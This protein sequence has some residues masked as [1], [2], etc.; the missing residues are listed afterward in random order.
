MEKFF[1]SDGDVVTVTEIFNPD[2][3]FYRTVKFSSYTSYGLSVPVSAGSLALSVNAVENANRAGN[4]F[5]WY[6]SGHI[7]NAVDMGFI[8][9]DMG[10]YRGLKAVNQSLGLVSIACSAYD[11]G[12]EWLSG[13]DLTSAT[14]K[15]AL[16]VSVT[17]IGMLCPGPIGIIV[18]FV[19]FL[20]SNI[21]QNYQNNKKR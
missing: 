7:S 19:Y 8:R 17:A 4:N 20:G 15:L 14:I 6:R 21:Y 11:F 1:G 2:G 5:K 10:F 9:N 16:D 3:S 18:P 13:G 12:N